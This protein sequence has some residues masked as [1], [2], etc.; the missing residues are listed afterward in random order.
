M[1]EFEA[2]V[3]GSNPRMNSFFSGFRK[4]K[5]DQSEQLFLNH[6]DFFSALCIF[7]ENFLLRQLVPLQFYEKFYLASLED[8][9]G[10][11]ARRCFY[12]SFGFSGLCVLFSSLKSIFGTV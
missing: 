3:L 10:F 11:S 5:R 4:N 8:F 9:L 12:F 1:S 6:S 2:R 7:I